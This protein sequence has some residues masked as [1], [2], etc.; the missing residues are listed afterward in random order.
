MTGFDRHTRA[1]D[2]HHSRRRAR[3]SVSLKRRYRI[4]A[5][6]SRCLCTPL[7]QPIGMWSLMANE[8]LWVQTE[9]G[10]H[11]VSKC[12]LYCD[13]CPAF[14][15]GL[16]QGCPR[17]SLEEC[18]VKACAHRKEITTCQECTRDSCYHFEAYY[19]R[20]QMVRRRIKRLMIKERVSDGA[21]SSKGS[22]GCGSG[23]CG[24]GSGCGGCGTGAKGE[25]AGCGAVQRMVQRLTAQL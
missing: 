2:G 14:I 11:I 23:G 15:H 6:R 18:V 12:G 7:R 21:A 4:P 9:D 25:M 13:T 1:C 24:T 20:R 5:A 22:G 3:V 19:E 16:C 17:L 10:R 8:S